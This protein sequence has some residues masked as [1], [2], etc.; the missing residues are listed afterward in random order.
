MA[1]L[2][3][4]VKRTRV[5]VPVV[6]ALLASPAAASAQGWYLL[7]APLGAAFG[8]RAVEIADDA[9]L[10]HWE[11]S[12]WYA[13][14]PECEARKAEQLTMAA[15]EITRVARLSPR[16]PDWPDLALRVMLDRKRAVLGLCISVAD[17][18]L[19]RK[20]LSQSP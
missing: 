15:N 4:P 18:R 10:D 13:T 8:P 3:F 9:P 17:P 20:P 11:R 2:Y 19:L 7:R 16:P 6:I 5:V 12:H 14:L 1:S